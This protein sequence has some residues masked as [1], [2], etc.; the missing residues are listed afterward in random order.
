MDTDSGVSLNPRYLSVI[1]WAKVVKPVWGA[2]GT[3]A[4]QPFAGLETRN[5]KDR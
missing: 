3:A 4:G 2:R 5:G 1:E